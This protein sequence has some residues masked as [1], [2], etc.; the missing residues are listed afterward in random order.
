MIRFSLSEYLAADSREQIEIAARVDHG[1]REGMP[2]NVVDFGRDGVSE[3]RVRDNLAL[4][5]EL[6]SS[7]EVDVG[8]TGID[9]KAVTRR[10]FCVI[11]EFGHPQ[12]DFSYLEEQA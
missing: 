9:G 6:L 4:V 7:V 11:N 12:M 8:F 2:L 1:F 3:G 5:R 10:S